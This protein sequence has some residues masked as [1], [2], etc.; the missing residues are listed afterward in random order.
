MSGIVGSRLNIRGSGLVGSLGS[1]G[2][3]FT[4]SGAGVSAA[5]EAAA[6]GGKIA[7]VLQ[8]VN[9]GTET[10]GSATYVDITDFARTFTCEATS[11]KVLILVDLKGQ[12]KA[13]YRWWWQL[14]RD[15]TAIY[16]SDAMAATG[17][18]TFPSGGEGIEQWVAMYIDSPS[19]T[20]EISY[21]V[22]W[23]CQSAETLYLNRTY[24][25]N[26]TAG[27]NTASSITCM[28]ILA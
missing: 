15:S 28:E 13:G 25:N 16:V 6:G 4:S 7:Q 24:T 3:V 11:S 9:T 17:G 14:M 10:A 27:G 8:T 2:Q 19:S 18:N 23:K 20:S 1:D 26:V 12:G 5:F 21:N 22:E